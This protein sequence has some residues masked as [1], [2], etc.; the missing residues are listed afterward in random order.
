MYRTA[1]KGIFERVPQ[2]DGSLMLIPIPEYR[3]LGGFDERFELYFED[4]DLCRRA[5]R[6][7]GCHLFLQEWGLHVGGASFAVAGA[8]PFVT[9]RVSR[10][11]Y[12]L[13]W[14]GKKG[15]LLALLVA[16]LECLTRGLTGAAPSRRTLARALW[17]QALEI[18]QPGRRHYLTQVAPPSRARSS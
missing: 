3:A 17:A 1:P 11:R 7:N 13:K 8:S 5:N 14:Y 10:V 4:V 12:L 15:A 18:A 9:L 6:R 16:C 2:I